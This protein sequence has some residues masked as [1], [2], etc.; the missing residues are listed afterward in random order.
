MLTHTD[1]GYHSWRSYSGSIS[2]RANGHNVEGWGQ[3]KYGHPVDDAHPFD[4]EAYNSSYSGAHFTTWAFFCAPFSFK[5]KTDRTAIYRLLYIT[6]FCPTLAGAVLQL[7]MQRIKAGR[8][9]SSYQAAMNLYNAALPEGADR[10]DVDPAWSESVV[11][12]NTGESNKLEVEFK[13]YTSNM[14]KENNRVSPGIWLIY[15]GV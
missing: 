5:S 15:L 1:A 8:D 7:V 11:I 9:A 14:I 6:E 2:N 10:I 3:E 12:K 13:T 4:L